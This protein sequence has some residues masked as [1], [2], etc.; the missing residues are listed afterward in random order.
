MG[1]R[2]R[3]VGGL[4]GLGA[5]GDTTLRGGSDAEAS[6]RPASWDWGGPVHPRLARRDEGL[7][8]DL[9]G[10]Q[11]RPGAHGR[12]RP[13]RR[14]A[15]PGPADP[16]PA[17]GRGAGP[18]ALR[19]TAYLLVRNPC[20][21]LVEVEHTAEAIAGGDLCRRVPEATTATEVGRLTA[22]S[23]ACSPASRAP[24]ARGPPP[25]RR[26]A[27][28]VPDAPLRRRRQPRAADAL[29]LHSWVRRALPARRVAE[30][31]EPAGR[32]P[33]SSPRPRG[34]VPSSTTC[35]SSLVWTNSAPSPRS[36]GPRRAG[37]RRR[38]RRPRGHPTGR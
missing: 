17:G 34:W 23:T 38:Q 26:P 11:R 37:D 31:D 14:R 16:G 8:A 13:V 36:R 7:A 27:V 22:R 4:G 32:W 2:R 35:C 1:S 33:G 9:R 3:I 10:G 25:R 5:R 29:D 20:S 30:P 6:I 21:P 19:R 28:G 12:P 15:H 24:S 18:A